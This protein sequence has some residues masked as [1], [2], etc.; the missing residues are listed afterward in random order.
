V[1]QNSE[2]R[3]GELDKNDLL[4]SPFEQLKRWVQQAKE[5]Q[6]VEPT[7]MCLATATPEGRPSARYVLLRGLDE[8]GLVFFSNYES[9][10][11]RELATNP[12]ASATFWWG[13]L[14]R[15]VRIEGRVERT[16]SEESDAY[17]DSR[18][19]Q[20]R[21]ASAASPQSQVVE[22]RDE[23]EA[24]VEAL[25]E[26]EGEDI[27]R[28][29]HW[30]GYRIIPDRFEFWQGRPARLHDRLVYRLEQNGWVLERLAP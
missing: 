23:L 17:F 16:S 5:A 30:G 6:V 12:F 29:A 13:P 1:V 9:R 15:Q 11:G 28:P 4:A 25:R 24:I 19:L 10:K 26:R 20:S 22:D 3:L 7:A 21:I 8:R 14:E 27:R 2:Y 18:A